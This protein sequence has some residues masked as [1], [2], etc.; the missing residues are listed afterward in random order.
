MTLGSAI[1]IGQCNATELRPTDHS[2]VPS[3][4]RPIKKVRATRVNFHRRSDALRQYR[5]RLVCHPSVAYFTSRVA[6]RYAQW[7]D[8]RTDFSRSSSTEW[9]FQH[10][11]MRPGRARSALAQ[12]VPS[13][14]D[15][16]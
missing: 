12:V 15:R 7:P 13:S 8:R 2:I 16:I 11:S 9:A 1:G 10:T 4:V 5:F 14:R 3:A 6:K